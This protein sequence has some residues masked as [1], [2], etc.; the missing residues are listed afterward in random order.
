MKD[1]MALVE[2]LLLLHK[3]EE[4]ISAAHR[5]MIEGEVDTAVRYFLLDGVS[6][7]ILDIGSEIELALG[8]QRLEEI[9]TV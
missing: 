6:D 7:S 5:V 2:A 4:N 8:I 9:S 1:R 3:A